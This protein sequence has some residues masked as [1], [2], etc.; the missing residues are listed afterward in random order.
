MMNGMLTPAVEDRAR[1]RIEAAMRDLDYCTGCGRSM[2]VAVRDAEM[3]VECASLGS[4]TGLR[5]GI[6]AGF[7]DRHRIELPEGVLAAA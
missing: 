5:L 6:A 1:E 2:S 4:K 3:W 7:H